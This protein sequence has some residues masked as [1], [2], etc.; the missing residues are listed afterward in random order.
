[1]DKKKVLVIDDSAF[2]RKVIS[3]IINNDSSLEAIGTARN[4]ED[5]L[6]KVKQLKPDVVTLDI[7][8]PV[9]DGLTALKHIMDNHPTPVIMLSSLTYEGAESTITA[10]QYGAVDFINKTSGS[11][12]LDLSQKSAE[13]C[14]KVKDAANAKLHKSIDLSPEATPGE[15]TI[16]RNQSSKNFQ[17]EQT[18]VVVGVSTGGPKAL[19]EL[20]SRIP[21]SFSCPI[22]IVQHMPA[23]FTRSLAERLDR[24]SEISVKE[25]RHGELL[26]KGHAYIAPGDYHFEVK[27]IGRSLA[28]IIEQ[29]PAVN[30]HRPSV[31]RLFQS[32]A[33]ISH[34]NKVAVVLTGMGNDGTEGAKFLK[35]QDASTYLIAESKETAVIYGMP[36][37]IVEQANPNL[38]K[39][40]NEMADAIVEIVKQ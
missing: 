25:V 38:I 13:I 10:L 31:N 3:D 39:P 18:L 32:V 4:G 16:N 26:K 29:T 2:M 6:K 17:H 5:G 28:A 33:S 40:I 30:G 27:S 1:M 11:I 7:E 19:Q 20:L 24:L 12:S 23:Q 37:S 22:L 14:E 21:S 15:L 8:M 36:K 35:E 34:M 9:M